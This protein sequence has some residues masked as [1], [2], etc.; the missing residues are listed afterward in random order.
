[1]RRG[2]A[3]ILLVLTA[4][5]GKTVPR[6]EARSAATRDA[7]DKDAAQALAAETLEPEVEPA[8]DA[9]LN[10]RWARQMR[11]FTQG[12]TLSADG[13]VAVRS[14]DHVSVH[15]RR[16]G[17]TLADKDLTGVIAFGFDGPD[18]AT[19]LFADG[20]RRFVVASFAETERVPFSSPAY[21]VAL[22]PSRI[23][24]AF[25]DG[26]LRVYD[27]KSL[28]SLRELALDDRVTA[29]TVS[30]DGRR[31]ALGLGGDLGL[32]D[33]ETGAVDRQRVGTGLM[34]GV[35]A[36]GTAPTPDIEPPLFVAADARIGL[37]SAAERAFATRFTTLSSVQAASW[38]DDG[39]I[40]TVGRD[41][42][43]I[44][45]P[46]TGASRSLGGGITAG[47]SG[48]LLATDPA[49]RRLCVAES[50][51]RVSCFGR[52]GSATR[53]VVGPTPSAN[54]SS[55]TARVV[56]R[57]KRRLIVKTSGDAI[58]AAETLVRVYRYREVRIG[59]LRS[60]R[61]IDTTEGRVTR[62]DGDEVH[63]RIGEIRNVDGIED[64]L[65]PDATVELI[66]RQE[67]K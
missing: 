15:A 62:V 39:S 3:V 29:L 1:V 40:A 36:Y 47:Q 9:P 51:G 17:R 33:V 56:E 64:P 65:P 37:W 26:M 53:Q 32:L 45:D 30:D 61:W 58:P 46:T 16:G 48:G 10:L 8:D 13:R 21:R 42:V 27:R 14:N 12:L 20:L 28:E 44:V 2:L 31:V 66:W 23:V 7:A 57:R 59:E 18:A 34:V 11:P 19:A 41:G 63:V 4:A 38:L 54:K 60:G 49:G 5:C 24:V 25:E 6:P 67:R 43:L 52:G 22:S 35:L 50:G 55:A